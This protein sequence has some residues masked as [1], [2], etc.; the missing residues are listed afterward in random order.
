MF[1]CNVERKERGRNKGGEGRKGDMESSERKMT[2]EE[3]RVATT[4]DDGLDFMRMR[5]MAGHEG[6]Y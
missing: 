1:C 2:E 3:D 5:E 6:E 4:E